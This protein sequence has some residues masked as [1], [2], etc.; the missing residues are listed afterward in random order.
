MHAARGLSQS[1]IGQDLF[2]IDLAL[3]TPFPPQQ[4]PQV[5][6]VLCTPAPAQEQHTVTVSLQCNTNYNRKTRTLFNALASPVR[7]AEKILTYRTSYAVIRQVSANHGSALNGNNQVPE[8]STNW[9]R[10]IST[11]TCRVNHSKLAPCVLWPLSLR[12]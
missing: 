4:P 12:S 6:S 5:N 2:I 9:L 11:R 10:S 1:H 7:P 8:D 3:F